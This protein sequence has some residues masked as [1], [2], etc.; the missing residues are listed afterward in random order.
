[1]AQPGTE[2]GLD[3]KATGDKA[4]AEPPPE[5]PADTSRRTRIVLSFWLLVL[6]LG[7]P[8]WW[9]TTAIYRAELPLDEMLQWADGKVNT[10]G[11]GIV[12]SR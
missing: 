10:P 12:F 6:L 8:F 11:P 4:S 3:V 2:P 1:M 5:K 7:L 9:G